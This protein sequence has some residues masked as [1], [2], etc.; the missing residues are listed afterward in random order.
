[1]LATHISSLA[2]FSRALSVSV[3][4]GLLTL[5]VHLIAAS[6]PT[7]HLAEAHAKINEESIRKKN[8]NAFLANESGATGH[9][10]VHNFRNQQLE[11]R[12][13]VMSKG[14]DSMKPKRPMSR[15]I[16]IKKSNRL[17]FDEVSEPNCS[18]EQMYDWATW[19]LYHRITD[20]R[21]RYPIRYTDSPVSVAAETRSRDD[22]MKS[23]SCERIESGYEEERF[24]DGEVFD[25][26]L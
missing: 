5:C 14:E 17:L 20:Y 3:F 12:S 11:E 18:T 6:D 22:D 9:R 24:F 2:L 15:A 19:K 25:L 1:M 7:I 10:S 23:S 16:A 26:E 8:R 4:Y 13:T 21:R